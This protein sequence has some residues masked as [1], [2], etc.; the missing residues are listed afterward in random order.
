MLLKFSLIL[1]NFDKK[2]IDNEKKEKC[3]FEKL[4]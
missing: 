2:R 3:N 1:I 4:D